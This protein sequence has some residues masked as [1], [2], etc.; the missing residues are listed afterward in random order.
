MKKAKF[1]AA[2]LAATFA[3]TVAPILDT[4]ISNI[5]DSGNSGLLDFG[6]SHS[7]FAQGNGVDYQVGLH[8]IPLVTRTE[9]FVESDDKGELLRARWTGIRV[10]G[11][12]PFEPNIN[13]ALDAYTANE[14]KQFDKS[15]KE[16]VRDAR[17]DHSERAKYGADFFPAFENSSDIYVR[18]ADS[19]VVSMLEFVSSY[20]GGAHGMYGVIGKSFDTYTGKEMQLTDI[21]TSPTAM[22]S[23]IKQ[24][25]MF[26]YPNA[27]FRENNGAS[28]R[29]TVDQMA[30]DGHLI[31]TMDPRGVT[32][33]FN[34][35]IIGSYAEGIYTTTLL[36]SERPEIFKHDQYTQA[37]TWRGPHAYCMEIPGYLPVRLSDSPRGDRLAVMPDWEELTIDY[38]GEQLKDKF[39]ARKIRATFVSNQLDEK[40]QRFLYVDCEKE[41][42]QHALRVYALGNSAPVF[43]GEYAMS[44]F[45]SDMVGQ[46]GEDW[47]VMTN[48]QAFYMTAMPGSGYTPGTRLTC[49]VG[50]DGAPQV[51]EVEGAKG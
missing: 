16:M 27:S 22:T 48:P 46:N 5:S 21:F 43:V 25:L 3:F 30:K 34:P 24:Q 38:C 37:I 31:W 15:C 35:Y 33:Y 14:S 47:Y 18:R 1:L 39:K 10:T 19:L 8:H 9:H 11:P 50:E 7:A 26:D 23:A 32:F 40:E 44:R 12:V 6:W 42:G 29:Q 36:Y 20:M 2:A 17:L 49:R 4:G 41:N 28:M 51:Y 13:K 45:I